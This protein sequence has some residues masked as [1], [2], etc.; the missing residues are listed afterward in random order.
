MNGPAAGTR[1][2]GALTAQGLTVAL[3]GREVLHQVDL[4]LHHGWTAVIGPN[5]AGKSTLL[6]ALAG[7]LAPAAGRVTLADRPLADW[8]P[9]ARAA[10]IGWLSQHAQTTGE[11]AAIDLVRLGRLPHL[12]VFGVAGP[13]DEAAVRQAMA[14][15]ECEPLAQRPLATLSGGERQRVLLARLLAVQARVLLLD[16]PTTHLD[17][18]HQV[19]LMTLLRRLAGDHTVVSVLHDLSLALAADRLVVMRDGRVVITG[20]STDPRVHAALVEVFDRAVRVLPLEGGWVA[21]PRVR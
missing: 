2:T 6:R 13:A 19:A 1:V 14:Q 21:V 4:T 9:R 5:G 20:D 8:P 16:E 12:G 7:L 17:A 18:P 15:T 3:G 11:V 10:H